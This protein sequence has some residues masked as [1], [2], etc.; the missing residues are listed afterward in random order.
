MEISR[1]TGDFLG[2]TVSVSGYL[3][4]NPY[5]HED[6]HIFLDLKEGTG[7]IDVVFFEREAVKNPILRTLMKG[8]NVTV[9]G[10][11]NEYQNALEIV[12]TSIKKT[13]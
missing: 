4:S 13:K 1:I 12:G 5:I 10:K 2:R 6:G 9:S 11:V 8:D 7:K 3:A